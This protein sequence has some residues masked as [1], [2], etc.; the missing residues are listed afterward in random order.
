M[1]HAFGGTLNS[2]D[3]RV[4]PED[5]RAEPE[6]AVPGQP[7]SRPHGSAQPEAAL[8]APASGSCAHCGAAAESGS[9]TAEDLSYVYALGSIEPRYPT[10]SVEME[11]GQA[12][13]RID[14]DNMTDSQALRAALDEPGNSYLTRQLCWV[15]T[16]E[17]LETYIVV[18]RYQADHSLLAATLR[19]NPDSDDLDAI[20]G[21][22]GPFAPAQACNGLTLPVVAFDQLYSFDRNTLLKAIPKPEGVGAE[23]FRSACEQVFDRLMK[24]ADNA[25]ATDQHRALNYLAVRYP[26]IYSRVAKAFTDDFALSAVD[27]FPSTLNTARNIVDVVFSFRHRKSDFVEKSLVRVDVTDEF[28]FLVSKLTPYYDIQ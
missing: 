14:T 1:E 26:T 21:V 12:I 20:I 28:P 27:V 24:V 11:V 6:S 4:E 10:P 17:G 8:A 19:A 7:G 3:D 9:E 18:P 2:M 5:D 22:R 23:R 25:G 13:S 15:L 16:I